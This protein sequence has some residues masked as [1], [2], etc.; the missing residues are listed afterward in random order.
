MADQQPSPV[1]SPTT[2]RRGRRRP[3]RGAGV[4]VAGL[5]ALVCSSVLVWHDAG[6]T[7]SA[8]TGD[9]GDSWAA[10]TVSLSDDDNGSALFAAANL[11]PGSTGQQCITV[12]AT[13]TLPAAVRLYAVGATSTNG[14]AAQLA[15][16]VSWGG[17]GSYGSC[18]GF[19]QQGVLWSGSMATFPATSFATGL[20]SWTTTGVPGESR[21]Y[22]VAWTLSSTAPDSVQGG[23]ASAAF[24][25]E[26]QGV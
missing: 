6:A 15:V 14:L 23:T 2:A 4:L 26:A 10:G 8:S 20:G 18:A 21:V 16:T 11:K 7:W 9:A 12:T 13:G 24:T 17:G 5:A 22:R 19:V 3:G 25:W 1:P